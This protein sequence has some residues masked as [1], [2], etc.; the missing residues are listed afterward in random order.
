MSEAL[1]GIWFPIANNPHLH[2]QIN[3]QPTNNIQAAINAH[4]AILGKPGVNLQPPIRFPIANDHQ[5]HNSITA[6]LTDGNQLTI[7]A[8]ETSSTNR[9]TSIHTDYWSPF[10]RP[11]QPWWMDTPN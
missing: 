4:E 7:N 9:R 3:D 5:S 8:R 1:E 11:R 2:N 10:G 6:Q